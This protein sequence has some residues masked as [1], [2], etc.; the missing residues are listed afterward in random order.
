MKMT[1]TQRKMYS[2]LANRN[3]M[4]HIGAW[5]CA[6]IKWT[7]AI[8]HLKLLAFRIYKFSAIPLVNQI[9]L[10][11]VAIGD[12]LNSDVSAI[13]YL[14]ALTLALYLFTGKANIPH[15]SIAAF[16]NFEQPKHAWANIW[17]HSQRHV[18]KAADSSITL[19]VWTNQSQFRS[20]PSHKCLDFSFRK[21][22]QGWQID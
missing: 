15:H 1:G 18:K 21:R 5:S 2:I 9:Y 11:K 16:R 13:H 3:G 10:S 20:A 6:S 8:L 19:F 12:R 17:A 4:K 7:D 22:S 14:P